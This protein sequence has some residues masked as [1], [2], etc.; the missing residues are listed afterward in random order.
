M[1]PEPPYTRLLVADYAGCFR[2][3]AAVLPRLA[4][5]ALAG[6]DES[7]GYASWDARDTT[8]FALFDRGYMAGALGTA[9]L[10]AG[11]PG[12]VQDR[13]CLVFHLADAAALDEAF[14]LCAGAGAAVVA[15]PQDRPRWGATLR[16]AHLRDPDGNLLELQTY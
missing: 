9:D 14:A 4:G 16:A 7:S 11:A 15:E 13:A 5:A 2:F 10:P 3:Y 6:G 12:P 8:A 1:I